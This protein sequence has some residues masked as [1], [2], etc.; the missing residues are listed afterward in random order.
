MAWKI[1]GLIEGRSGSITV[2]PEWSIGE[3]NHFE[4]H[5]DAEAV[6]TAM[7]EIMKKEK[8]TLRYLIIPAI[9]E[10]L[11]TQLRGGRGDM[12]PNPQ[13]APPGLSFGAPPAPPAA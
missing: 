2:L 10:A 4:A 8:L 3:P 9:D 7:A 11:I 12:R 5:S 6:R 13:P 1:I